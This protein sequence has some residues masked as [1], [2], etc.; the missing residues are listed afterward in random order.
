MKR[1][2]LIIFTSGL[3]TFN[4]NAQCTP[5]PLYADSIYGAW[6][7]TV[8]NFV[9]GQVGVAYSQILDFKLPLDAGDV[10]PGFAGVPV[11]SAVLTQVTGLPA[12]L[13]Y[14]CNNTACSWLGG[15]QGCATLEGTPTTAGSYDITITLDGW[16]TVF[17]Q[18]FSQVLTFT[19]YVIDINP[20]LNEIIVGPRNDL[21]KKKIMLRDINLLCD[22]KIFKNEI[23]AKIRST[24]KLLRSKVKLNN[25]NA[26]LE[27][28]EDEYGISP[29]QACVFYS[30]DEFGDKV[31][32]G[33]WISKN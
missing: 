4:L 15:E 22:K 20:D 5:D 25:N 21:I 16:V 11:D 18:P 19:G 14:T 29:G 8:T 17:F 33:G 28:L 6:P 27:L 24:G 26:T 30:K 9:S 31:L 3:F 1:L 12:G 2:L 23:F 10:D 13:S 32:G 7:D